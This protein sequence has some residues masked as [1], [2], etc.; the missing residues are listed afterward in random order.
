MKKFYLDWNCVLNIQHS[1]NISAADLVIIKNYIDSGQGSIVFS[2]AHFLDMASKIYSQL[3]FND[4]KNHIYRDCKFIL[5]LTKLFYVKDESGVKLLEFDGGA[6]E[7]SKIALASAL[8]YFQIVDIKLSVS[9]SRVKET[10][11]KIAEGLIKLRKMAFSIKDAEAYKGFREDIL[12]II[13]RDDIDLDGTLYEA[14][15][16][17]FR[18]KN[19]DD[20]K[21]NLKRLMDQ[22]LSN[23]IDRD[24]SLSERVQYYCLL[25]D[26]NPI[27]RE[28]IQK[29]NNLSNLLRDSSH[30]AS[31]IDADFFVTNDSGLLLKSE[32]IYRS[33]NIGCSV[34]DIDGFINFIKN[35]VEKKDV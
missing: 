26:F 30:L 20:I 2:N 35:D 25:M 8:D 5:S 24:I 34:V 22:H 33:L 21:N 23:T 1:R 27:F 13:S 4:L 29:R 18:M 19:I 17:F 11:D 15:F 9:D 31:S 6:L 32:I 14:F 7:L 10:D 3:D 16:N 12:S 28:K